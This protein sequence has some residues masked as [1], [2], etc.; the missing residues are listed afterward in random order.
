MYPHEVDHACSK[1]ISILGLDENTLGEVKYKEL[2]EFLR[3]LTSVHY[4]KGHD[5]GYGMHAGYTVK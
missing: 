1:I 4:A 5:D 3:A 2:S